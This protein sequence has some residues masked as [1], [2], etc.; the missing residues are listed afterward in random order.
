MARHT[1][2]IKWLRFIR[3]EN[4][5]LIALLML[6]IREA[7]LA[8]LYAMAEVEL[9]LSF[10]DYVLLIFDLASVAVSGYWINDRADRAIDK[11]NRPERMLASEQLSD[12]AFWMFYAGT[13]IAGGIITLYLGWKH[14]ELSWCW[15]YPVSVF[16]FWGYAK[17]L[18]KQGLIGNLLVSFF[19]ASIVL[20]ALIAEPGIFSILHFIEALDLFGALLFFA[21]IAFLANLARE[22]VKDCEDVPGD[23]QHGVRSLPIVI[24]MDSTMRVVAFILFLL[25]ALEAV[26]YQRFATS[27][28]HW[29][30][31][32]S[33]VLV[34]A[35]LVIMIWKALQLKDTGR[36]RLLSQSLKLLMMLGLIQ[37]V[38][39]AQ[40]LVSG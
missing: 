37:L 5:F 31:S 40:D 32:V 27:L 7:V 13:V 4:I 1:L 9:R 26:M 34:I 30:S 2:T 28:N 33:F 24:G 25:L 35:M 17:T 8:P 36:F 38:V 19:I 20:I 3:I 15:L 22:F 6:V 16:A 39:L 10:L 18:K 11:I 21:F 14:D 12:R 29:T 23:R